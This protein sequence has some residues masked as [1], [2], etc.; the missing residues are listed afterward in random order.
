MGDAEADAL[1][2]L[3]RAHQGSIGQFKSRRVNQGNLVDL[4]RGAIV[5]LSYHLYSPPCPNPPPNPPE[6]G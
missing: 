6:N 5:S 1:T 4:P 3:K 2:V